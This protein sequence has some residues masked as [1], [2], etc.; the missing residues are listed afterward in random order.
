M[1]AT[2]CL[3][4]LPLC[5]FLTSFAICLPL[6]NSPPCLPFL[7]QIF[8]TLM[9]LTCWSPFHRLQMHLSLN[10]SKNIS[11]SENYSSEEE[12][13]Y[14]FQQFLAFQFWTVQLFEP[15]RFRCF[16]CKIVAFS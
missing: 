7:S 16:I 3:A 10:I 1:C 2:C 6:D 8:N 15:K 13:T 4:D 5:S 9:Q 14:N 11:K 12:F